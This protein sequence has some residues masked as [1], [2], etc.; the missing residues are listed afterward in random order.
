M[1]FVVIV[2]KTENVVQNETEHEC[3]IREWRIVVRRGLSR[4]RVGPL[5]WGSWECAVSWCGVELLVE[6]GSWARVNAWSR[7]VCSIVSEW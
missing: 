2:Y 3:V 7:M 5:W 4:S 6:R 1:Q